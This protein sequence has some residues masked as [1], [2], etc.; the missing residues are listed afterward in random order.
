MHEC[1]LENL[2]LFNLFTVSLQVLFDLNLSFNIF[3]INKYFF[4]LKKNFVI[5]L[6]G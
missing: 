1:H 6:I 5:L 4:T 3:S 2:I